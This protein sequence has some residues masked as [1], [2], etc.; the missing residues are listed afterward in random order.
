MSLFLVDSSVWIDYF[1]GSDNID[2][3][4]F[5]DLIDNNQICTNNLIL[6]ELIPFL[7]HQ[8]HEDAIDVLES[9]K[10]I[11]IEINWTEIIDIQTKNLKNGINNV[12][13]S[14]IIIMQNTITNS[15]TL[16]SLDKH[17]KLMSRLFKFS[18]I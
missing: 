3:S 5:D 15:L 10:N 8:K 16:Y 14:D 6:S 18:I 1:R 2:I 11:P 12:G 4:F 17:F 9:F 7:R 13:I